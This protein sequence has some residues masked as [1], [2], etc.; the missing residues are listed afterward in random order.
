MKQP[1]IS[2]LSVKGWFDV[3]TIV[4]EHIVKHLIPEL[5]ASGAQGIIEYPLNKVIDWFLLMHFRRM[6]KHALW[7][8]A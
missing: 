6:T 5:K 8:K 2:E 4:D 7:Q 3:D 1:T